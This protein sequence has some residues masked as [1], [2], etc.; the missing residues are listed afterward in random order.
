MYGP[1][2]LGLA[3]AKLLVW[4]KK[5]D[6]KVEALEKTGLNYYLRFAPRGYAHSSLRSRVV[7]NTPLICATLICRCALL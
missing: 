4:G 3:G 6:L 2:G 5:V 1:L 7:V